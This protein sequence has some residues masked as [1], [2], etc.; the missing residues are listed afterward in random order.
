MNAI[1]EIYK[2][3]GMAFTNYSYCC[4]CIRNND[5]RVTNTETIQKNG[6]TIHIMHTVKINPLTEI[7]FKQP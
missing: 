7:F 2:V 3:N 4:E 1:T 5:L 6:I